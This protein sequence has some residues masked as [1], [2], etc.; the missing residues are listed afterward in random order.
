MTSLDEAQRGPR[1]QAGTGATLRRAFA[2]VERLQRRLEESERARTEPVAI[3]GVGCRFPGGVTDADSYWQLLADGTDAIGEIP[4][5]RWD[6]AAFHSAEPQTPGRMSTRWGGFLDRIDHFDHEFF[7]IS[8]RE[9]LAMD[10]QQRLTLEV[11]WEALEHAGQ[12]P[13]GLAGSRTG[14]FMGVCS[15]DFASRTLR[16]PLDATAYASTGTAHSIVT[17]RVSYTLDLHGPSVAVDSAC[18]ASLV[19]VH[20][21]CQS[22]R[23]GECDLALGGGVNVVLSPIPSIAF[24]QFPGMVAPDGRCKTFDAAANGYVRGEGCGVVVLKRLSDAVRDGDRVLAVI[25]GSAVNQDGRSAGVTAPSGTAQRDVLRRA[26]A[27]G[28][29]APE[30]VSYIEAHG[31]GTTLGDPI[32]VEALAEVYGRPE[33]PTVYL[34]SGKPNIGHLEAASGIA[35]LIKAALCVNRGAIP[36][37]VHFNE[38]NPHLSFDGT[39]F[40]VPTE[41]TGW[42]KVPGRRLAGVSSFGFSGTNVH[43]LVEEPPERP[44]AD[45]DDRRP[46]AALALSAKSDAALVELA[47]RYHRFLT[48]N[49]SVPAGDVCFSANTGR[50]HFPHRL[51]A[52]GSDARELAARLDD[53]LAGM[54]AVGLAAGRAGT[55]ETVFVF[56]GQGPQR[57]GMARGLY[58]TQPTFRR[59]IDRCDEILRPMLDIPLLTLL[60]PPDGDGD[61]GTQPVYRTEYSQPALFSVEYALAEL[62]RSWGV[63]PAAVLGHSFGEYAAACFAG[64]M[65]LEDGLKLVVARGRLMRESGRTGA[66]ATVF[67][68]EEEVAAAIAGYEDQV[69]IAAVNGPANTSVSG[70]RAVIDAVC[71]EFTRRGVRAKVLRITTASHSPLIE[72]IIE[73]FRAVAREITFTPPRIPLVSNLNGRLWEWEQA[74]DADYWCRH[75]RQP[76]RFADGVATVLGLGHRAFVEMGPAPTLLGLISDGLPADTD[77]LLLPSLR[78]RQDDWEVILDSLS[79]LYVRG[80]D[81]DWRAFDA[82]YTRTRVTVPGYPFARTPCWQEPPP[83]GSPAAAAL[84]GT[85]G[86]AG[87]GTV[88]EGGEADGADAEFPDAELVY[89]LAWEEAGP[90]GG[91]LPAAPAAADGAAWLLLADT[92]GVADRLAGLLTGQGARCVS[93]DRGEAYAFAPGAARAVVRPDSAEDWRRLVTDLAVPGDTALRVVHLWGLDDRGPHGA[94]PDGGE[95][96]DGDPVARLLDAQRAG[97]LG[98]VRAVQALARA[99][100][101]GAAPARLW[102]VTRG[103]VRPQGSAGDPSATGQATLWGLGRSL[104]QEHAG[105]WGGLVDLDPD[106]AADA[107]ALAERL[108]AEAVFEDGEDQVALRGERRLVA[109][110]V[111]RELPAGPAAAVAWRTDA[112]YL[113]TGGL[114]GLGLAVARSMVLAGARHLVLAG[115]TPLPPRGEWAALP[116]DTAAGRRVAAVRELEA[117]GAHVTVEVL[118]VADE[119]RVR[120]FLERFDRE[121]RPPVRG[122]VHAAGVGEVVPVLELGPA[123]LERSLRAKAGGAVVLD[124]VFEGRELDFF[125]LFS[126]VSSL[127]SSPFVAGYAAANAFLDALAH[128]RRERGRPAVSVNWGIWRELGMAERG[129]EATPGLSAGMGTLD[130]R[131][132]LRMFHRLLGHAGPQAAVVPVDWDEWGRRYQEV[133]GSPLLTRLLAEAAP[134][135]GAQPARTAAGRTGTLPGREELLALPEPERAEV[136]A[137]RL[138]VGLAATLRAEPE[139]VGLD[140]SLY[141]LGLDSLMAVEARN[142][143][144]G[145]TGVFLPISVFLGGASV[146]DLAREIVAGLGGDGAPAGPDAAAPAEAEAAVAAP[147]G[148]AIRRVERA[149]DDLVGR[150]LAE[151]DALPEPGAGPEEGAGV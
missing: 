130:P 13:A 52:V 115:R 21:A 75:L 9:A 68:P 140:Q 85:A 60:Y 67:A 74:P 145:R 41:L 120:A 51:A 96:G 151:L 139:T 104:Q 55:T 76:V 4:A 22:L 7:G 119:G 150:L 116:A 1:E 5:D 24:S 117:L 79:Q 109:R 125:V 126:S 146:R 82:D 106:P 12:S 121:A 102:L 81:L 123:E 42:P 35:G 97:F 33:G 87:A 124:R 77:A 137:E 63:E 64:A 44:A 91:G 93:V 59:V 112:S 61:D 78:P 70:D 148:G 135:G 141:E 131:Q 3:V 34:G 43:M 95:S 25:R 30:E 58:E 90:A 129:A 103:A 98:A 88:P 108:L 136:L 86:T 53:F 49:P 14:V 113:I 28:R 27:A 10:P 127:L 71:E 143:I 31:T 8:R 57:V 142:E 38:L 32:E 89:D 69:S 134:A 111:R 46:L 23:A 66:M 29:V 80:A 107:G 118:D 47:G 50:S 132:A 114:G 56:P 62:W 72:P 144:E 39:T 18:S 19:A 40:A 26:L 17:G 48:E 11:V 149:E 73:E 54:P 122:V 128:A 37:N 6:G 84:P 133:S 147:D 2:T 15:N 138:R 92:T 101:G 99:H 100:S 94:S 110:L 16:D 83:V 105:L 36:R 20:T 65:S 45:P